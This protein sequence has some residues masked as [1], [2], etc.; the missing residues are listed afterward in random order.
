MEQRPLCCS[1]GRK[2]PVSD[3]VT[4]LKP[5]QYSNFFQVQVTSDTGKEYLIESWSNLH[6]KWVLL[7]WR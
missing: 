6:V 2:L 3:G 4:G 1:P 7:R 5:S